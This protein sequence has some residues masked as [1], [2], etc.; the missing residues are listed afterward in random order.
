MNSIF[1]P[2]RIERSA[3]VTGSRAVAKQLLRLGKKIQNGPVL[4]NSESYIT[5]L[6]RS[7]SVDYEPLVL[8]ASPLLG[9]RSSGPKRLKGR[10]LSR[11]PP[12]LFCNFGYNH[13][14]EDQ[15]IQSAN[16]TYPTTLVQRLY[17]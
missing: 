13:A 11:S 15:T 8:R 3:L 17:R 16:H 7:I 10:N 2:L 5:R 1:R 6:F 14:G 12:W 4:Y 9:Y